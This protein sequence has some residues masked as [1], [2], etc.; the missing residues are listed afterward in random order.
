M[1]AGRIVTVISIL[2]AITIGVT[3]Y[4]WYRYNSASSIS[5]QASR[6]DD[7]S[8]LRELLN[9]IHGKAPVVCRQQASSFSG[10]AKKETYIAG[11]M[12]RVDFTDL[13]NG[14]VEHII[15]TSA[16]FYVWSDGED[17]ALVTDVDIP[18]SNNGPGNEVSAL[19]FEQDCQPW[20]SPDMSLFKVPAN[21]LLDDRRAEMI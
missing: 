7:P 8:T 11:N 18:L 17:T 4:F 14:N 1:L 16:G 5:A 6:L 12:L 2:F 13:S 15:L 3:G 20:W 9:T 21:L 19:K 10:A